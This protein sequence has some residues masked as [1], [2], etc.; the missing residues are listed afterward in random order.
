M[1]TPTDEAMLLACARYQYVTAEQWCRYFEDPGK[2]RYVQRRGRALA[3]QDYLLRQHLARTPGAG[4]APYVFTL[5]P[6]GRAHVASLGIPIPQ[7]FRPGDITNLS[8]RH[9]E[10]SAAITDVLLSF[11]L[12]AKR[13]GRITV[14][15]L[16]HE[17]FL[18]ERRFKVA[19]P[20]LQPLTGEPGTRVVQIVPDAFVRVVAR[21]A[22]GYRSFP[23][24]IE[25]DRDTERQVAFREKIANLYAFG[26]SEAY[27]RHYGAR[28][29]NVAVFLPPAHGDPQA[30]LAEVLDWTE[31]ELAQR[32]LEHEAISFSF[33]ALDP[34]T[35][36]PAEL[37]L[38]P[39][40]YSPFDTTPHALIELSASAEGGI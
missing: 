39:H 1:L 18:H 3:A 7:R 9:L 19:V 25:V 26:M 4:K 28:S 30:R 17:R 20:I 22:D 24:D 6:K 12:L 5:G 16:L 29:F 33:C 37:L 35:T 38:G 21:A 10:H 31:R 13:D 23:L 2:R 8:P 14:A 27:E 15:D 11:D 36:P 40:W 32:G 34:V